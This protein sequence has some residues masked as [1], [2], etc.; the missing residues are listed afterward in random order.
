MKTTAILLFV[1]LTLNAHSTVWNVANVGFTFDPDTLTITA[2]DSVNFSIGG[3]H[4]VVEVSESN[5][6]SNSNTPLPGFSLP[7]GGGLLLPAELTVGTHW[8]VCGPHASLGMKGIIIVQPG[9]GTIENSSDI[10][11]NLYPN[12][13]NGQFEITVEGTLS[14]ASLEV[15]NVVGERVYQASI[16][17]PTTLV[18]LSEQP[19]G[20]YFVRI[21][22]SLAV[23]TREVNIQ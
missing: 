2:G 10:G 18:D 17:A 19:A 6:D 1:S 22:T 9:V 4:T 5:W 3:S 21:T 14:R 23:A 11:L 13:S 7:G 12:P 15:F 20:T 8:Y 16:T